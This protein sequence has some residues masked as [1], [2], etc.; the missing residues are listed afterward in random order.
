MDRRW[1]VLPEPV[2]LCVLGAGPVA[3]AYDA[4]H[5]ATLTAP[6]GTVVTVE[7]TW[8][9]VDDETVEIRR[10]ARVE[11][12]GA[13]A[14]V[15]L[16]LRA[17]TAF[18]G[19]RSMADWE[20]FIP[21]ALYKRNDTDHDGAEDYLG[22]YVQDHRDDR[23]ASL[24][25]LA[26]A[27]ALRRYAALTRAEAPQ[28]DTPIAPAQRLARQ[29]VQETDV[30]SLGLAP[31][32][33]Q[34]ELRA[35]LPFAEEHSFCLNTAG[36]GWAAYAPNE[37]G[38][39]LTA[40]YRLRV[41]PADSLT[42]AIWEV[43]RAQ[44][45]TL[46]TAPRPPGFTFAAALVARNLLTQQYYRE[47]P[48]DPREPAGYLVH[49]SPRSGRT[50]GSLL[51]YGFSGAQ[52]LLAYTSI[53]HG[54]RQGVPLWIERAQRV[55]R[56]FVEHCQAPNGFS[57]GMYDTARR[58]FAYWFT[59]ILMPFQYAGDVRRY[60]GTQVTE[61]LAPVARALREVRGNYTRT[62]CESVYPV[63]LAYRA[64]RRRGREHPDWLAAGERFGGFLLAT[65]AEDG[66]WRRAYDV[67]GAAL[68]E[69][70]QWFGASD[71]ERKSGTLFPIEVLALLHEL[72]G[73]ERWLEAA[74]RAGDFLIA[75]Y[76][77]PV[78]Y[79][80]G[81]NDTTHI[82]SVKTD[83]VGVMFAMR[84]LLK[85]YERTGR[86]RHLDAAT[87]AAQILASWVFLWDVP[88]PPGSPLAD[89]GFKSTGWA[90]CDVIPGGS[91]VDNEL[92]EFTG[93][94]VNVAAAAGEPA[95]LDVAE[96]VEHGMHHALSMP[97]AMH[98]YVAPGIQCE[99]VMTAYWMSDP[100]V[101]EFSGAVNKVKG[102]DNDTCNGLTNGQA[103][104]ALFE[105]E[106]RYGTTDFAELRRRLFGTPAGDG[107]PPPAGSPVSGGS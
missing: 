92:L 87:R 21:G 97:G 19:P 66:S 48:E 69:P 31:A 57:H 7:D 82:K 67:D 10:R 52:T 51:E 77:D 74:E 9:A 53:E 68:S 42:A 88:M 20:L 100:E 85:L 30:G 75:T 8:R 91:Y 26:Y 16:E 79:V 65:Q 28:R 5:R 23:L 1:I 3:A 50:L 99:G 12:A 61:A 2:R 64:E 107:E 106:E 90:V 6:D 60:L 34:I 40:T 89:T 4:E 81:L 22:T 56:F 36:D 27:P 95:L 76:V 39:E 18:P 25:V 49:F 35:S 105:L 33:G 84:S 11:R 59:G 37:P 54:H 24:A 62:M 73:A 47:W 14:G 58:E 29:F 44:M 70:R 15:R 72:T 41:A 86:T 104:Y 83:S 46:A 43:T 103:A 13:S 98:G 96:I 45:E 38:R 102:Q 63:L 17:L 101:T 32:G 80:G 55:I 93:D 94:L 71:T 78:E